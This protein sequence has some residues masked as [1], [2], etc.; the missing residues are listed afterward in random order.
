MIIF[1]YFVIFGAFAVTVFTLG[2]KDALKAAEEFRKYFICE[3]IPKPG[4]VCERG[5]MQFSQPVLTT[6]ATVFLGLIPVPNLVFVIDSKHI[7]WLC[8]RCRDK[9]W[10]IITSTCIMQ[11]LLF[12]WMEYSVYNYSEWYIVSSKHQFLILLM[13]LYT[14]ILS[15]SLCCFHSSVSG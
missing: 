3:A 2:T 13:R 8:R 1:I 9:Q 5:F 10:F 6:L 14:I 11:R 4:Q 7:K 12:I 15:T